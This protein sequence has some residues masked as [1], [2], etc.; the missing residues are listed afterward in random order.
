MCPL[1]HEAL[2]GIMIA[3]IT[4]VWLDHLSNPIICQLKYFKPV[5]ADL[6]KA[7]LMH[8]VCYGSGAKMSELKR[9]YQIVILNLLID[10]K[11][12]PIINTGFL[13]NL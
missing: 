4:L 2:R 13:I 10:Y 6:E 8:P 1:T 12:K 5:L 7:V 3:V 11:Q 9:W